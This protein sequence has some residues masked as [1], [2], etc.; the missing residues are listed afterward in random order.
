M[1]GATVAAVLT[2]F[3][4][5]AASP[6]AAQADPAAMARLGQLVTACEAA[7]SGM[8]APPAPQAGDGPMPPAP[9]ALA[10][11]TEAG[12]DQMAAAQAAQMRTLEIAQGGGQPDQVR[13][14]LDGVAPS[15]G[16]QDWQG[17]CDQALALDGLAGRG[18]D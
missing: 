11:T 8:A 16:H 6:L 2:A 4:A 1:R 18:G 7:W 9:P 12:M 15:M 17:L 13:A 14:T 10:P 3:G 5:L